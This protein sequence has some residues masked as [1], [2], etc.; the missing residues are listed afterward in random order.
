[1]DIDRERRRAHAE[2]LREEQEGLRQSA[3][4][5][6]STAEAERVSAED[7]RRAVASEV[8]ATIATLATRIDGCQL[9]PVSLAASRA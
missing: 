2:S 3:E 6:R 4:R 8:S 7:G 9:A 1:M 5:A